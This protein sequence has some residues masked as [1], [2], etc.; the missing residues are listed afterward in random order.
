MLARRNGWYAQLQD[1]PPEKLIFLDEAGVQTNLTR[2]R[3]R[4]LMGTRLYAIA[5][6]GH[7][8]TNT[9]ISA[10]RLRGPCATI[11]CDGPTDSPVFPPILRAYPNNP[12][13]RYV[14]TAQT[15]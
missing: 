5:P 15:R 2:L 8:H 7:A 6:R 4:S 9:L 14:M 12:E 3:G 11:V 13:Q 1:V 10:I